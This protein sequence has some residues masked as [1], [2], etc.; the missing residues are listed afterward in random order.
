M[1][2]FYAHIIDLGDVHAELL[3]LDLTDQEKKSPYFGY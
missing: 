2:H 3:I 1:K